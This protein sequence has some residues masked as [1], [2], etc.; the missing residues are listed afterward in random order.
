MQT[1]IQISM[2]KVDRGNSLRGFCDVGENEN[3]AMDNGNYSGGGILQNSPRLRQ[4][5]ELS[6]LQLSAIDCESSLW[7]CGLRRASCN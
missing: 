2:G 6:S 4:D 5:K 3:K 1:E 7:V